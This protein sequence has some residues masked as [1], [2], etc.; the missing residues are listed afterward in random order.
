MQVE[1]MHLEILCFKQVNDMFCG[2]IMFCARKMNTHGDVM[3]H[4]RGT[5]M[6]ADFCKR[7]ERHSDALPAKLSGCHC[8]ICLMQGK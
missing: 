6:L 7:N 4:A 3:L 2:D 5:K 8:H 1:C